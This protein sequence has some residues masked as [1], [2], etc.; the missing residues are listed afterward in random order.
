MPFR[1]GK[2]ARP[3]VESD[4][5]SATVPS[6]HRGVTHGGLGDLSNLV[7]IEDAPIPLERVPRLLGEVRGF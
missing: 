7:A 6:K 2:R 3:L 4:E 5:E 1:R